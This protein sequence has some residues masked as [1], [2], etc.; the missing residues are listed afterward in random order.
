MI[1]ILETMKTYSVEDCLTEEAVVTK[2]R[3]CQIHY[4]FLHSTLRRNSSGMTFLHSRCILNK[5]GCY[6]IHS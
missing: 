5:D 1:S 4:L 3:T 6:V 2:L